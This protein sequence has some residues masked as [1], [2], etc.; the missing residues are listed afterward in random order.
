[1]FT[2]LISLVQDQ[3]MCRVRR[4]V[5]RVRSEYGMLKYKRGEEDGE[6]EEPGK[7]RGGKRREM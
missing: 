7:E 3:R 4:L 5:N 1:M 6:W 2:D